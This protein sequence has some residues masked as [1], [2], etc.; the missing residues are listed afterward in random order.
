MKYFLSLS[1]FFFTIFSLAQDST[2]VA[3]KGKI[4]VDTPDIEGVTVFNISSN[5]GTITDE[6]GEFTLQVMLNDK[7]EV[8]ALQFKDFS[9][10]VTESIIK[11]KQMTIIFVFIK[12]FLFYQHDLPC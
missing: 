8:S 2:R 3:V 11:N 10:T 5:K 9:L 1:L 4:I 6:K 12:E 7:V